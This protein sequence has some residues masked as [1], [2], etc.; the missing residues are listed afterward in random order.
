MTATPRPVAAATLIAAGAVLALVLAGCAEEPDDRLAEPA[1]PTDRPGHDIP[2]TLARADW[3]TGHLQA[4]IY[5]QLLAE[6]GYDVTDPAEHTMPP[7]TFYPMLARGELDLWANGW[8]PLH[9]PFL[10]RELVTGQRIAEPIEPVGAQVPDG[11]VQGYLVD[12]A[13]AE[14]LDITSM[15]DFTR[16]EVVDAFD[17]D[18]DGR[19]DLYGC[20][21]GWGC[22]REIVEHLDTFAWGGSVELVSGDYAE[23]FAEVRE[24]VE[25]G[26]PALYYTWTPNWTT[27]VLEPGTDVVWLE[28]PALPDETAPTAVEGLVGCAGDDPCDLG[29]AVNDIRAVANRD[30]L[31]AN[32]PVRRLLEVVEIP[33]DDIAAHNADVV[34]DDDATDADVTAAAEAWIEANRGTVD[35]W[36]ATARGE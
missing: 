18:G 31:D 26:E 24:R 7:G 2:V 10:E 22:H 12:K 21:E 33:L 28:A 3:D 27:A 11:A 25:A 36:L 23:L 34:A 15:E 5:E 14:E 17:H 6:L 1:H 32:P 9:E 4:A 30:F 16:P 19:A 35:A 8:F 20:D 29:W 13:T